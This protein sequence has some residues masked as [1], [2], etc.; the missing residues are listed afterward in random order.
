MRRGREWGNIKQRGGMN[1]RNLSEHEECENWIWTWFSGLH[2]MGAVFL[3][4]F[5]I[6]FYNFLFSRE[7]KVRENRRPTDIE[8]G[9]I[10]CTIPVL[11]D[12]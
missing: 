2:F 1:K 12:I 8:C 9:Y 5:T 6:F 11:V 7:K 3:Y 10:L 4:Q